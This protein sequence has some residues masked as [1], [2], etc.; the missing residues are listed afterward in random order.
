MKE[1]TYRRIAAVETAAGVLKFLSRQREPVSGSAVAQG[2]GIPTP[3]AMC[4][5]V[6]LE[7]Q[8]FVRRIGEGWEL[9]MALMLFWAAKKSQL[10]TRIEQLQ[11]DLSAID[12]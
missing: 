6:T 9:G 11:A 1:T 8:G 4:H 2:C 3:T 12:V 7:D 10:S 5:L